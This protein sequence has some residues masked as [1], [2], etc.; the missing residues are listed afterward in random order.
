MASEHTHRPPAK[1]R[2]F[3]WPDR[4]ALIEAAAAR[5]VAIG[6]DAIAQRGRFAWA[7]S[8]GSTPRP[9][10]V[11]LASKRFA[12]ALDWSRVDFF[13]SD[14]R[15]VAPDHADSNYQMARGALLDQLP[16]SAAQVSR[17]HGEDAPAQAAAN[18]EQLLRAH[19]QAAG[20]LDLVLLGMGADGHTASLFPGSAALSEAT[21]WVVPN[22]A[23][24][25]GQRITFTF[26]A[27][28][29]ARNAMLLVAGADKAERVRQALREP[30]AGLPVQRVQPSEGPVEWMLDADAAGGLA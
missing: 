19:V 23:P 24:A 15:C 11:L 2:T 18:Y 16:L 29:A 21:R 17:I 1:P 25:G 13:W 14:E 28:N 9:L 3:V 20:A 27:I 12:R 4:T 7:L 22:V 6:Q 8:G 26:P 5:I 10:Y 30:D